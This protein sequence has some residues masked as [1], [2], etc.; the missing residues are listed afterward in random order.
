VKKSGAG[1]SRVNS[2]IPGI[3]CGDVDKC[4]SYFPNGSTVTLTAVAE[5]G[6]KFTAWEGDCNGIES[7]IVKLDKPRTVSAI[8]DA[9]PYQIFSR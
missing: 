4:S 3:D 7:C 2:T 5:P 6:S 1:Y 9:V 8:I